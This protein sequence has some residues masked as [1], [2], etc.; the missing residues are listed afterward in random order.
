MSPADRPVTALGLPGRVVTALHRAGI[1][2]AVQAAARTPAEL[3]DLR[4]VGDAA[5]AALEAA[6]APWRAGAELTLED[7]IAAAIG[8]PG[9]ILP[10]ERNENVTRWATRAV[11]TVL[12]EDV[13]A[14]PQP[15]VK[16]DRDTVLGLIHRRLE[17]ASLHWRTEKVSP[18]AW[19]AI[20]ASVAANLPGRTEAQV[21]AEALRE[22]C[23]RL[24]LSNDDVIGGRDLRNWLRTRAD[25]IERGEQP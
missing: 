3:R 24:P 8:D 20:A 10:R 23:G 9:S 14:T 5:A 15:A 13:A 19:E 2:T 12:L 7:R 21:K 18:D 17:W 25:R 4:E 6:L 22:I 11:L 16:P 1:T